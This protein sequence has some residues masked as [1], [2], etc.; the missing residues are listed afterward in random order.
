MPGT[1][2]STTTSKKTSPETKL[3]L[4]S[5]RTLPTCP[6]DGKPKS[7]PARTITGPTGLFPVRSIET[8]SV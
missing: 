1:S 6:G 8:I 4:P 7:E 2:T 3:P 5:V